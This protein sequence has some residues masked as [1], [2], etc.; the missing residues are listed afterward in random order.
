MAADTWRPRKHADA[1]P[2]DVRKKN[3]SNNAATENCRGDLGEVPAD[4]YDATYNLACHKTLCSLGCSTS[5]ATDGFLGKADAGSAPTEYG[6]GSGSMVGLVEE[7]DADVDEVRTPYVVPEDG[8][9][10]SGTEI[11]LDSW[12]GAVGGE[13]AKALDVGIGEVEGAR[14]LVVEKD[15]GA[16]HKGPGLDLKAGRQA[17]RS[18]GAGAGKIAGSSADG[19]GT[20]PFALA[21]QPRP[22]PSRSPRQAA[23][24]R[25]QNRR[26]EYLRRN[27]SYVENV[28]LYHEL[29]RAFQ[30]PD[31]RRAEAR[32]KGFGQVLEA[33]MLR[34]PERLH[35]IGE[36]EEEEEEEGHGID[37]NDRATAGDLDLDDEDGSDATSPRDAASRRWQAIVRNWFV[38][39]GASADGFD[40]VTVDDDSDYDVLARADAEEAWFD[41][42]SPG[43][44]DADDDDRTRT[45]DTG[46]Q[47]Y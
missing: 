42:E 35:R 31:E 7:A 17:T 28:Q 45:G 6:F 3:H 40:Y 8:G 33:S 12:A 10:A 23:R 39:G 43:W 1:G 14:C 5:T 46:V 34:N 18:T 25:V 41:D 36:E 47:D 19:N 13:T 4:K 24:I 44:A 16:R 27:P 22:R 2:D 9:A 21:S 37:Q 30:T 29:V 32:D 15:V 11:A 26:L 38:S 20:A